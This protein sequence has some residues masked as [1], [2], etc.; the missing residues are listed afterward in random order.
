MTAC[1][2]ET[3]E[4]QKQ[5]LPVLAPYWPADNSSNIGRSQALPTIRAT[6]SAD[7]QVL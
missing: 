7:E 4:I 1:F 2:S 6:S 5:D 3:Y